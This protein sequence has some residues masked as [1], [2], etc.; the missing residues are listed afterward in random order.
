MADDQRQTRI[1]ED[2]KRVLLRSWSVRF[3]AF[4][5]AV[6]SYTLNHLDVLASALASVLSMLPPE[7]RV[8][9]PLPVMF[10][11]FGAYLLLRFWKQKP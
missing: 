10:A 1:V 7:L 9:V 4:V 2:W 11:I 5:T 6:G 3:V 8:F